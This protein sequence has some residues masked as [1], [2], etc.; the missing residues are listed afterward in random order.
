MGY[1]VC[2]KG[3]NQCFLKFFECS[4]Q[5]GQHSDG[6]FSKKNWFWP[7]NNPNT[8]LKVNYF[9]DFRALCYWMMIWEW[10]LWGFFAATTTYLVTKSHQKFIARPIIIIVASNYWEFFYRNL[11]LVNRNLT[12]VK[13]V[14]T[15][16]ML[17]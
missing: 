12:K 3:Q 7:C 5:R 4:T 13:K 14:T 10:F 2:L 11:I 8:H 16:V 1:T 17:W 6:I 9:S 15:S